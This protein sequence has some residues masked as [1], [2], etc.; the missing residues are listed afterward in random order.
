MDQ[1][2]RVLFEGYKVNKMKTGH[3]LLKAKIG[4][5]NQTV[6]VAYLS[7]A[8]TTT[9]C[10]PGDPKGCSEEQILEQYEIVGRLEDLSNWPQLWTIKEQMSAAD[11]FTSLGQEKGGYQVLGQIH[12]E[13]KSRQYKQ[14]HEHKWC[15]TCGFHTLHL[16]DGEYIECR[17][18]G[19][20]RFDTEYYTL[21]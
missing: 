16:V 18:C 5:T 9:F 3:Y 2:R 14:R 19:Q 13:G 11:E 1:S 12:D 17:F 10:F 4:H 20:R 15:Y 7:G 21:D 8:V 6:K